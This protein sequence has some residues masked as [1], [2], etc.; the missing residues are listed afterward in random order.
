MNQEAL[1]SLIDKAKSQINQFK[2]DV[3]LLRTNPKYG[4]GIEKS[5]EVLSK[6]STHSKSAYGSL[7]HRV[8]RSKSLA[9][10]SVASKSWASDLSANESP[11]SESSTSAPTER[12]A[13]YTPV[14]DKEPPM[15][16]RVTYTP[17]VDADAPAASTSSARNVPRIGRLKLDMKK[18]LAGFVDVALLVGLATITAIA[19]RNT[20]QQHDWIGVAAS[21]AIGLGGLFGYFRGLI[22]NIVS[23]I[24]MVVALLAA[25]QLGM[26]YEHLLTEQFGTA[27]IL[28]RG[29]A[30]AAV[31]LLVYLTFVIM[32]AML[33]TLLTRP[34]FMLSPL[35]RICGTVAGGFHA[36]VISAVVLGWLTVLAP[37][38]P[39]S[40]T[41]ADSSTTATASATWGTSL[42]TAIQQ[43]QM[44]ASLDRFN[45]LARLPM[46]RDVKSMSATIPKLDSP[47]KLRHLMRHARMMELRQAPEMKEAVQRLAQE[48]ELVKMMTSPNTT[49]AAEVLL[50][51]PAVLN[52]VE[53]PGFLSAA[54][55][56]MNDGPEFT[57]S[58][59]TTR[60]TS[61]EE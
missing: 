50:Q 41:T 14:V 6:L 59:T 7:M 34:S 42:V 49:S 23:L 27:G 3:D 44:L 60:Y 55:Q 53:Q 24:G 8:R 35:H 48:P 56:I 43:S 25:P 61:V 26:D 9:S 33:L 38:L 22:P 36:A 57:S 29:L 39:Q 11:A 54:E 52:L 31:T 47:Q 40:T 19:V 21:L 4:P 30:I 20:Y 17:I 45:P 2:Q 32:S 46:F 15:E 18:R 10:K 16:P 12:T 51:S 37:M 5:L 1:R 58:A 13:T 28:N